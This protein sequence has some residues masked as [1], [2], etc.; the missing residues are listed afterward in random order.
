MTQQPGGV[1]A[2]YVRTNTA[3]LSFVAFPDG[4]VPLEVE[5]HRWLKHYGVE[6]ENLIGIDGSGLRY[7][8]NMY[9][10]FT[11]SNELQ[12]FL[13]KTEDGMLSFDGR[14]VYVESCETKPTF[15]KI[16]RMPLEMELLDIQ[17]TLE[18][19]GRVFSCKREYYSGDGYLETAK[20]RAIAS[21]RI[22]KNIPS[23]I[24]VNGMRMRIWYDG[25][26]K[27]CI[28]C[29]ETGHL[30]AQCPFSSQRSQRNIRSEPSGPNAVSSQSNVRP[31][32]QPANQT[33]LRPKEKE[34][35]QEKTNA[36][37]NQE[38]KIDR[39]MEKM[40]QE[41]ARSEKRKTTREYKDEIER[42]R[43]LEKKGQETDSED[44]EFQEARSRSSSLPG[45]LTRGMKRNKRSQRTESQTGQA[46]LSSRLESIE[47][48]I[49]SVE[50]IVQSSNSPSASQA[51][52]LIDYAETSFSSVE[53][54]ET[55]KAR[56]RENAEDM[57]IS[58]QE[59]PKNSQL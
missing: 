49:D 14:F 23:F 58:Q 39:E 34:N 11:T 56:T 35:G 32:K 16:E 2:R 31:E 15:V 27:T 9:V 1:P 12:K 4:D 17:E 55:K 28:I 13:A 10:K 8:K 24:F 22:D 52:E 29:D 57:V 47:G 37:K 5:V 30:A 54:L 25:Q 33:S 50:E 45:V 59:F 20:T 7:R 46:E 38:E 41:L 19:Y 53:G 44:E 42:K 21:M 26:I 48:M 51:L 43:K 40:K 36:R 18:R 6:K 3:F